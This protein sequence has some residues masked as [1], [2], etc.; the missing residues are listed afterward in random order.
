MPANLSTARALL[1]PGDEVGVVESVMAASEVYT[2]VGGEV[3][4]VNDA[5]EEEPG[6]VNADAQG[7]GWL[8]KIRLSD[9]G[10]LEDLMNSSEYKD[11]LAGLE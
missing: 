3:T 8:F 11:Y 5:L 10:D 2:P 9:P 7:D 4:A 1:E 6:R